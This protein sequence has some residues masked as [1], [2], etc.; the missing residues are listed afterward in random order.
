MIDDEQFN[1]MVSRINSLNSD[2][3]NGG[4]R[5]FDWATRYDQV[6]ENAHITKNEFMQEMRRRKGLLPRQINVT[7]QK[8]VS[9]PR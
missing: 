9:K 8:F 7:V 5:H 6:F 2:Y 4:I 1:A 3:S